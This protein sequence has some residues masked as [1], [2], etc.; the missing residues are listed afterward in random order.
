[1]DKKEILARAQKNI[2]PDEGQQYIRR[3]AFESSAFLFTLLCVL[4]II[5]DLIQGR[6]SYELF[7]VYCGYWAAYYLSK[8]RSIKERGELI[9]SICYLVAT[10]SFATAYVL[11]VLE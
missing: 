1:M 2:R 11:A 4:L 6:H 5:F 7:T 8:Y 10:L 9:C 3:K